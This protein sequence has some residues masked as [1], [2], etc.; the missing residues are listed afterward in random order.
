MSTNGVRSPFACR[1][2]CRRSLRALRCQPLN[3]MS[4]P[5]NSA[6]NSIVANLYSSQDIASLLAPGCSVPLTVPTSQQQRGGLV[7]PAV[8]P[9]D[10][11]TSICMSKDDQQLPT[12]LASA[13]RSSRCRPP[14]RLRSTASGSSRSFPHDS[15]INSLRRATRHPRNP[16]NQNTNPNQN[17]IINASPNATSAS[18]CL[19]RGS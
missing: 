5:N 15:F 1:V 7:P 17:Q 18:P 9:R 12:Q 2:R 11:P 13:P 6:V 8:S 19:S 3:P 10:R 14:C 4:I 16:P